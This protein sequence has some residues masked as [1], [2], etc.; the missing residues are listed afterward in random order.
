MAHL[1]DPIQ[2]KSVFRASTVASTSSA[3]ARNPTVPKS[4]RTILPLSDTPSLTTDR[5]ALRTIDPEKSAIKSHLRVQNYWIDA[6]IEK[7]VGTQFSRGRTDLQGSQAP[8]G[9][10]AAHF[11]LAPHTLD[12][13]TH[14][15]IDSVVN[16]GLTPV[17]SKP[18][19]R[20]RIEMTSP[21]GKILHSKHRD[22]NFVK[23]FIL[24]KL[25]NGAS[26]SSLYGTRF[27]LSRNAT[28][29]NPDESNQ[30]DSLLERNIKP[31]LEDLRTQRSDG[32]IDEDAATA[33]LVEWLIDYYETSIE[34]SQQRLDQLSSFFAIQRRLSQFEDLYS[35]SVDLP[36]E[37]FQE[38]IKAAEQLLDCK[39]LL[40]TK[41]DSTFR[42]HNIKQVRNDYYYLSALVRANNKG[43]SLSALESFFYKNVRYFAARPI[44]AEDSLRQKYEFFILEAKAQLDG[45]QAFADPC[46]IPALKTALFGVCV[47]G[48]RVAPSE[49]ELREQVYSIFKLAT[50]YKSKMQSRLR[51]DEN[52]DPLPNLPRTPESKQSSAAKRLCLD[53][54]SEDEPF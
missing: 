17:R 22:P 7:V 5:E 30:F 6:L 19:L 25:P 28:F 35:D 40:L 15:V 24:S 45:I 10:Q 48:K 37:E 51:H 20:A 36:E 11:S 34:N 16:N 29:E 52:E 21:E 26:D 33:Q 23:N 49:S 4:G 13:L 14:H 53:K 2:T 38:Y 54:S 41:L 18:F 31:L 8:S 32:T 43:S 47:E 46:T 42:C 1:T 12:T 3:L 27:S 50:P 44:I 9:W 39:A